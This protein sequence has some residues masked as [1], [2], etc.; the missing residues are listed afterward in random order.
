MES[1]QNAETQEI[2]EATLWWRILTQSKIT[3]REILPEPH[4]R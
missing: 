1:F 4:M 3:D 2:Q